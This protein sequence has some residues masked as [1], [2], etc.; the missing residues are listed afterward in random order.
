M[1]SAFGDQ[2]F[3]LLDTEDLKDKDTIKVVDFDG[4]PL[5]TLNVQELNNSSTETSDERGSLGS[6]DT[7]I[8]SSPESTSSQRS[9]PWP[10]EFEVPQFVY[11]TELILEAANEAQMKDGTVL[12]NLSA[13]SDIL[14]K[15]SERIFQ[16]TAYPSSLQIWQV[17]EAL[18]KNYPCLKEPGSFSGLYGWQTS[19]KYKMG[20][21]RSKL[22]GIGFPELEVNSVK[23]ITRGQARCQEH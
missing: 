5:I 23:R 3:S 4:P 13:K 10:S 22:R 18:V 16:F 2:L 8:L 7:V 14:E 19:L 1:D 15:L 9:S 20:N 17:A 11:D 12:N 6:R 21:Y